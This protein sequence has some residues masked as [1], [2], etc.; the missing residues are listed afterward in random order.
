MRVEFQHDPNLIGEMKR[1]TVI[2]FPQQYVGAR[3]FKDTLKAVLLDLRFS[4][5]ISH[6]KVDGVD[7]AMLVGNRWEQVRVDGFCFEE[8]LIKDM[9]A[10][11][12][13][14]DVIWDVGA[15]TGTHTIPAALKTGSGGTVYA[16]EPDRDCVKGLKENLALNEINNVIVCDVALWKEDTYL[17]LYSDGRRGNAGQVG[18]IE[19]PKVNDFKHKRQVMARS[20][21]SLVGSGRFKSPDILKIDVEG[22]GQSVLEGL[23]TARP[24]HI[25]M[26]IHPLLGENRDE[27]VE[28]LRLRDYEIVWEKPRQGEL[29]IHF[30]CH[31]KAG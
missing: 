10:S 19:K 24:G 8:E 6:K 26:E 3:Q 21:A 1:W 18:E 13:S 2:H 28:F 31:Q 29:H 14:G 20:I 12:K 30:F 5:Y 4:S 23:G 11:I 25:F 7:F 16:F 15:A 22:A 27:I 17:T 9:A